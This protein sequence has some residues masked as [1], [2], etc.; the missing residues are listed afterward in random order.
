MDTVRAD[1]LFG[2]AHSKWLI[3]SEAQRLIDLDSEEDWYGG[4]PILNP[5]ILDE[6][7]FKWYTGCMND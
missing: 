4:A 2:E 6:A 1:G 5:I 7:T 3:T